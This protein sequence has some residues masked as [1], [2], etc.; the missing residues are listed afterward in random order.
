M[1]CSPPCAPGCG[2][3]PVVYYGHSTMQDF[4]DSFVGSNLLAP[5]FGRWIRFC[6]DLGDVVITPTPYSQQICWR[7]TT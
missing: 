3:R 4:R 1:Q 5:L 2:G 6:Y 7:V